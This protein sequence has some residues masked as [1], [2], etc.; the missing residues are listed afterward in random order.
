M[1][2]NILRLFISIFIFVLL[3]SYSKA[4]PREG[5]GEPLGIYEGEIGIKIISFSQ[6]WSSEEKLKEIY[7]ELLR[8]FHGEEISYLSTIYVYPDSPDGVAANYYADFEINEEGKYIYKKDRYIEIF[9]GDE[10]KDI[11]ELARILSHEYGHHFTLYYLLTKENKHFNQWEQTNY[12]KVRGLLN[13]K[14]VEYYSIND[15][16]YIHKWDIAEIAAEDYV[17]LFGS[18]NAKKSVDYKDVKERVEEGIKDYYYNN[19]SF[20]LLPQENLSIPLAADVPGLYLYWLELA[21]YTSIEPKLPLKP[22]INIKKTKEIMPGYYQYEITWDEIEDGNNYEY[23][24]VSYPVGDNNFPRPIKTVVTGEEMKAYIGS[25]I[26][27]NDEGKI[28]LILDDQY[29]GEYYFRLFIKNSKGFIFSTDPIKF[30]FK[31]DNNKPLYIMQDVS[32]DHWAREFITTI[33]DK[34]IAQGYEDGTFRPENNIT[35]AEF[36]KML[37]KSIDYT[38][39]IKDD[40]NYW[41]EREGYLEAAKDIGLIIENNYNAEYDEPITREEVAFMIGNMLKYLGF[42]ED[43]SEN[44]NFED[45]QQIKYKSQLNMAIKYSIINGYPDNTYKPFKYLTR[46]E[47]TKIIYKL[48]NILE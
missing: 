6:N 33:I 42:E 43:D 38:L 23:T 46:A 12:A 8:N 16:G 15:T 27:T 44:I 22:S 30:E 36:M 7:D 35:K 28:N 20:N 26:S 47:A 25:A 37:I 24:L 9:N 39:E 4:N 14:D 18:P 5:Y 32:Q 13:Y 40:S 45:A 1:K 29:K 41:F 10:Y 21:G 11:S 17:Q 31:E 2:K 19:I 3:G 34:K 48:I